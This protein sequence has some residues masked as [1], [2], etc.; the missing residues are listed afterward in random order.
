MISGGTPPRV[1]N[2]SLILRAAAG[3]AGTGA[4]DRWQWKEPVGRCHYLRCRQLMGSHLRY[5]M[6]TN[7]PASGSSAVSAGVRAQ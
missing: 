1:R 3:V 4:A 5:F 2:A 6:V 7:R